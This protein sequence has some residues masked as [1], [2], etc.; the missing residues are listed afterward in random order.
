M[1]GCAMTGCK[2]YKTAENVSFV[3]KPDGDCADC[4]YFC[5]AN[6]GQHAPSAQSGGQ[7]LFSYGVP[8]GTY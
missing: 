7:G 3:N 5:A 8:D 4:V 1:K 6:C 2:K